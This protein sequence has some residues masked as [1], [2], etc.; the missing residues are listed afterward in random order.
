MELKVSVEEFKKAL[1][2]AKKAL[3]KIILQEERGHVLC[4]LKDSKL[5]VSATNNDI[6]AQV[7]VEVPEFSD[8]DISFTVDPKVV[9]KLIS[10]I[11][12]DMLT[13]QYNPED[14]TLLIYTTENRQ[15]FTTLQSFPTEK[16]L[17]VDSI[18]QDTT[19]RYTIDREIVLASLE[20]SND[21]L[22]PL[23]ENK[24]Q[25]D[26]I[27]INNG[28]VYGAN[29]VNKMGFFVS[30]AFKGFDNFKIRKESAPALVAVLKSLKDKNVVFVDAKKDIGI[31]TE[32]GSVF[33]SCLKSGVESPKINSDLLKGE[34]PY[35]LIDKN[36]L[37]K[38]LDRLVASTNSSVGAGVEFI[39]SG[40]NENASISFTL[41][42][43][44]KTIEQMDCVRVKDSENEDITHVLDFKLFSGILGSFENKDIR[45]YINDTGKFFKV[46]SSGEIN[47][48]K[49]MS[50]GVGSYSKVINN[51]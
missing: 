51:G 28:F 48:Y 14:K 42:S 18:D 37:L 9:E 31:E 34:S 46:T 27:I 38:V 21:Y 35:T 44:L 17:T 16:M 26:F 1:S 47:G 45:L 49:Y 2:I 24:K 19:T 43:N 10:K 33:F 20:F 36:K 30:Q 32:D 25:Y 50:A 12:T 22:S 11:D 13:I 40:V 3:P 23:K 41:I 6:K 39:L 7:L 15:S 29:G 5:V 8:P 4:V